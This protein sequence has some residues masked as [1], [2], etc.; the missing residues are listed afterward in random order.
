MNDSFLQSISQNLNIKSHKKNKGSLNLSAVRVVDVILTQKDIDKYLNSTLYKTLNQE[1]VIGSVIFGG[2]KA[3]LYDKNEQG[4]IGVARPA[5]PNVK[6]LP[7]KKEIIFIIDLP[8]YGLVDTNNAEANTSNSTFYYLFPIS[9]WDNTN[10]NALPEEIYI[11][12]TPN[13]L[14]SDYN[15]VAAGNPNIVN[16]EFHDIDLGL[17]FKETD[18]VQHLQPYEGDVIHEGRWGNSLRFGSTVIGTDNSWSDSPNNGDPII[19][20]RNGFYNNNK[21]YYE[22][23]VEDI[24]QDP[25]SIYLTTTQKLPIKASSKLYSSYRPDIIP[26]NPEEYIGNQIVI[27]SNRVLINSKEDHVLLSGK[28]SVGLSSDDSINIDAQTDFIV[29]TNKG[30][31]LLGDMDETKTQPLLLGDKT[32]DLIS[33]LLLDLQDLCGQLSSLASLPPGT[34]FLPLNTVAIQFNIKLQNY[35]SQLPSLLSQISKTK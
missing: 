29:K 20:L 4:A 7:V 25:S 2:V 31:I 19:I 5:F 34:P 23:I 16:T 10:H 30:K 8:T 27:T 1:V 6:Y 35:Q 21:K 13:S 9:I 22:T 33:N 14:R 28:K 11:P 3:P 24:N 15:A 32:V 12:E 18:K 17:T 26:T